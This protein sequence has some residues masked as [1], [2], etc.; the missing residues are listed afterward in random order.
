MAENEV[1]AVGG[2]IPRVTEDVWVEEKARVHLWRLLLQNKIVLISGTMVLLFVLVGL[3][4]PLL[5]PYNYA[6]QDLNNAYARPLS[7]GHILG[8]D[9]LGRDVLT[10]IAYGIRISLYVS[11]VVTVLSLVVGM[12]V[13]FLAGYY[14]GRLDF[15]LSSL[16]DMAWGFPMM[17]IAIV[18]VA[19]IGPG[20]PAILIGMSVVTWS[21]FARIIRG[22]V[23]ALKERE[24]IEASRALGIGNSRIFLR[25]IIPNV[26]APTMVMASFYMGIVIVAEA[27]LSFVGLGAQPPLP[28]LG[29]IISESRSYIFLDI[30]L[31]VIPGIVLA[32]GILGFNLLGDGLRDLLDPRLRI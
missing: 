27:T 4:G 26:V 18:F 13:G 17:L 16:M 29:Q 14:G 12:A 28:S 7:P 22:E 21:G 11:A 19:I 15:V 20:I 3:V 5:T 9:H 24:F 1:L 32:F 6:E 2:G 25:H 30:W 8:T 10:R 23:L 31:T